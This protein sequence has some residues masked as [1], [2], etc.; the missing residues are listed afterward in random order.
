ME[1]LGGKRL[2]PLEIAD[3]NSAFERDLLTWRWN[4]FQALGV[5]GEG[6]ADEPAVRPSEFACAHR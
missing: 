1:R 4:L 2:F 5:T 6:S 3:K